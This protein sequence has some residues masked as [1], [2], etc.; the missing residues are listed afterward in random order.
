MWQVIFHETF[1]EEFMELPADVQDAIL[2]H[3][4]LLEMFGPQLSRPHADTL[5]GSKYS[6]MK[7]LRFDADNGVWRVA[8]AFDHQRQA[9]LLVA[10]DKSGTGQ[11][12]FYKQLIKKADE[13]FKDWLKSQKGE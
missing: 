5:E 6:N 8:F 3:K 2:S 7:E 13:R 1:D 4:G 9:V 12:R 11:K 10:G